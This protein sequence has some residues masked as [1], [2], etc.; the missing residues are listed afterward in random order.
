MEKIIQA[1]NHIVQLSDK[2]CSN[3]SEIL[4]TTTLNKGEHWIMEGKKN[5]NVAFIVEGYLRKFYSKEGKEITDFF[6]FENDFSVD[7]PSILGNTYPQANIVA[8]Q[9]STLTTFLYYDF[10]ELC[11]QSH[12]LEHLH[13]VLV[14][15]TF[16][17]FYKRSV[18]FILQ[19][20]M[21]R[22]N[23]L[24]VIY[25]NVFQK[26]AQYHIASYL[27]ISPQHLSRLRGKKIIS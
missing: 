2:D 1:F 23:D 10:N 14:E 20:P 21:E 27:G 17:R 26:A 7:L 16:L 4:H 5:Y 9:K 6:Y 18:S 15:L 25:P 11:K 24:M 3:L 19:T 8:M 12:T 13:R 22:Y